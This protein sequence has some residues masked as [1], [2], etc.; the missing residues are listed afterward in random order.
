MVLK[1]KASS[2][3]KAKLE[4]KVEPSPVGTEKKVNP[5]PPDTSGQSF[6]GHDSPQTPL[7]VYLSGNFTPQNLVQ[8]VVMAEILRKPRCRDWRRKF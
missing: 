5:A 1:V 7:A 8:G 4:P 3:C 6:L 2:A